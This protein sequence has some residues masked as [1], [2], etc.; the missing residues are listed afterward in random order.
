LSI[1]VAAILFT[2]WLVMLITGDRARGGDSG[3][4]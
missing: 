1:P 4:E 2:T 3:R